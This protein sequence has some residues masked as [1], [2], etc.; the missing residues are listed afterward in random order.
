[1]TRIVHA[2]STMADGLFRA[3]ADNA[4]LVADLKIDRLMPI[5]VETERIPNRPDSA[6]DS[7]A[8]IPD[9]SGRRFFILC[10]R[11]LSPR[12]MCYDSSKQ[13]EWE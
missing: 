7:R 6:L 12:S 13:L 11:V 2:S 9:G 3:Q 8:R 1:M 4:V 5:V 10:G